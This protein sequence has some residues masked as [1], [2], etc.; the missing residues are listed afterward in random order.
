M[1]LP[2][3]KSLSAAEEHKSLITLN[4]EART[5]NREIS[6]FPLKTSSS[7]EAWYFLSARH[8]YKHRYYSLHGLLYYSFSL[9][10]PFCVCDGISVSWK[11]LLSKLQGVCWTL[12]WLWSPSD[13]PLTFSLNRYIVIAVCSLIA[14][15]IHFSFDQHNSILAV[16]VIVM[17]SSWRHV[18]L[19]WL[20][21]RSTWNSRRGYTWLGEGVSQ[22]FAPH[23]SVIK[24]IKWLASFPSPCTSH[25]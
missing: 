23:E 9:L 17:F 25:F 7:L 16:L 15:K 6:L 10:S 18:C 21:L 8:L 19:C 2:G 1:W 24:L 22:C 20:L 5:W 4:R 14:H 13:F 12:P 11:Q 3:L